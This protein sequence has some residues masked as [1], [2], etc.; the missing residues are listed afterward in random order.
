M[1]HRGYSDTDAPF[2]SKFVLKV[3]QPLGQ[4]F[5]Y[6]VSTIRWRKKLNYDEQEVDHGLSMSYRWSA[7]VA[8]KSPEGWFK[9]QFF[10][11]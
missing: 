5:A 8:A 11:F 7:Y 4:V 9:K 1:M 2:R 6:N 10:I 3:A